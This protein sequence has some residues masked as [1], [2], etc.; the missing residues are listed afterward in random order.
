MADA[1]SSY[2]SGDRVFPFVH[3]RNE[4]LSV[5]D[6]PLFANILAGVEPYRGQRV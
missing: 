4:A 6:P 5:L 3:T 2:R 1:Q